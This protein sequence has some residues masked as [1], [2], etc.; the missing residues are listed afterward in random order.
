MVHPAEHV[1]D[2]YTWAVRGG[3]VA[4]TVAPTVPVNR[5]WSYLVSLEPH[6]D[7]K[8][9]TGDD[10]CVLTLLEGRTGQARASGWT[11]H[12]YHACPTTRARQGTDLHRGICRGE[13]PE[14]IVV[15]S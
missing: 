15:I 6:R 12:V 3:T 2:Q 1:G 9:E 13:R 10:G 4:C 5:T 7:G 11:K 14:K 8:D